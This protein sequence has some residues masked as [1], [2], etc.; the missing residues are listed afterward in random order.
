MSRAKHYGA[1]TA[2]AIATHGRSQRLVARGGKFEDMD[3]SEGRDIG[4][5]VMIGRRQACVSSSDLSDTSLDKLAERAVA[6]AGLAPED[7]Y[8][9]LADPELLATDTPELDLFDSTEVTPETLLERARAVESATLS[10]KGVMQ[11]E[12]SSASASTSTLFFMTSHGFARGWRNSH[13]GLSGLALAMQDETME[14][15]YDFESAHFL[16]DLSAPDIIGRTAGERAIARLGARKLPSGHM[17][18]MFDK[19]VS[20]S[21]LSTLPGAIHGRAIGR[22]TSFLKD[23]M[24]KRIFG[25]HINVIDDP[26][27]R[28][29]HA[30][31]PWDGEGVRVRETRLVKDGILQ[32]W[33]LDSSAARQLKL[34]PTGHAARGVGAPP[35][36]S[37]SNTYMVPGDKTPQTLMEDMGEGLLI[38][39]MF[40]PSLN[41]NTGDY[42]VG[43]TGFKIEKGEIA[44]AVNEITV[45]GNLKEIYRTIIPANDL[46]FDGAT[47]APSLLVEG[48]TVAGI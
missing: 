33:L 2:D 22:G 1:E 32:T 18:V 13:H 8:C 24:G 27:M 36:I 15:D 40:G 42:S 30:S 39:E 41:S 16:E 23:A 29:G 9:G 35:G 37:S 38:T 7:P 44:Y 48:L 21:L 11:A 46:V 47:V 19:R 25:A 3:N 45:A 17:P 43:V 12:G 14:R 4:L 31:R 26:L 20:G 5:R 10:I 28:R 34:Q 6:M